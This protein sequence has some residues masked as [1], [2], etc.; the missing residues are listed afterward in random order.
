MRCDGRGECLRKIIEEG[1]RETLERSG[2]LAKMYIYVRARSP[3]ASCGEMAN[4]RGTALKRRCSDCTLQDDL[5]F[6]RRNVSS[7]EMYPFQT[8]I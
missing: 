1:G 6:S 7:L 5:L 8:M 2:R 4:L 3:V